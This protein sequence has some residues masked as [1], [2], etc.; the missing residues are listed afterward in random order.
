M[1]KTGYGSTFI[2][3]PTSHSAVLAEPEKIEELLLL[4][5]Q[6]AR[7]QGWQ[8]GEQLRAYG[9]H[10]IYFALMMGGQVCGGLHLVLGG[11]GTALPCLSVWPELELGGRANVADI[12]LLALEPSCRGMQALFWPLCVE[13]WRCCRSR[14]IVQLWAEVTPAN[15]R[16]YRRLGW[17]LRAAGPLR[18]HWNELC[19][20]CCMSVQDVVDA[21]F[22]KAQT[23]GRHRHILEQAFRTEDA[24]QVFPLQAS[25]L[26]AVMPQVSVLTAEGGSA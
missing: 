1:E 6:V 21:L 7:E 22:V 13:M 3:K 25:M 2:I 14:G 24:P 5:E 16:R 11:N 26:Q 8:P 9:S 15:L 12:A 20:P 23:S 19:Y 10:S 4:F 18:L 17:P